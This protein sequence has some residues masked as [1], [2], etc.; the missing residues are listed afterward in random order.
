VTNSTLATDPAERWRKDAT[1]PDTDA[2]SRL[3]L[4]AMA[5]HMSSDRLAARRAALID[6]LSGGGVHSGDNLRGAVA[7]QVGADCWGK[8][9]A[10]ALLRDLKALRRGGIRID[11]SR[12]RGLE[13]YY[14]GYPALKSSVES[15]FNR[16]DRVWIERVQTM[17]VPEKNEAA[18][19]AADF[20]LRQ[21][22]LILR[23]E[24]PEWSPDQV[25]REARRLVF[26]ALPYE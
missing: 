22:R 2:R 4:A 14:L 6:V 19:A 20:A 26:G 16:L 11:Y 8:R 25:E 21:K 3:R 9:P 10:E 5:G 12:Q 24:Q 23:E 13:G 18:F 7:A 17:G 15:R 1:S